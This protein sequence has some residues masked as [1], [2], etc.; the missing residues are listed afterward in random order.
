L[1]VRTRSGEDLGVM[2]LDEVLTL[3]N[4]DVASRGHHRLEE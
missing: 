4:S 3:I 1:A 2:T